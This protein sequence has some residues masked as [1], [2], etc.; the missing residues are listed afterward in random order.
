[1]KSKSMYPYTYKST[2]SKIPSEQNG[3]TGIR[4]NPPPPSSSRICRSYGRSGAGLRD[5]ILPKL[6][7]AALKTITSRQAMRMA[8]D[9]M[10]HWLSDRDGSCGIC[11]LCV[12]EAKSEPHAELGVSLIVSSRCSRHKD[13]L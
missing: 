3:R 2:P 12:Q 8:L 13:L 9:G 4:G 11:I 5:T 7:D 1:M 10:A 6:K